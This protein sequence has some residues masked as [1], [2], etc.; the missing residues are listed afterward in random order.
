MI[1]TASAAPTSAPATAP[2]SLM[3]CD[4]LEP[5]KVLERHDSTSA[6]VRLRG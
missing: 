5:A 6:F 4:R 1:S 3:V 2:P